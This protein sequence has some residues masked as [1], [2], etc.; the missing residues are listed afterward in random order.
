MCQLFTS[1]RTVWWMVSAA[2]E[3]HI[4]DHVYTNISGR[5]VAFWSRLVTS[6]W[7]GCYPDAFIPE[8]F[9]KRLA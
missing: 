7:P 5:L 4:H 6:V 3:K 1:A 9:E 2:W 8:T